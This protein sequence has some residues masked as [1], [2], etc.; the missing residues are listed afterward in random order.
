MHDIE[1]DADLLHV[2]VPSTMTL[3][4]LFD[5]L[6]LLETIYGFAILDMC[7]K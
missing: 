2:H 5:P 1:E 3:C 7:L 6:K 4:F